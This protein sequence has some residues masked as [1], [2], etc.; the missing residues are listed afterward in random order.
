[1]IARH[2]L[3]ILEILVSVVLLAIV[4]GVCVPFLR[5]PDHANAASEYSEFVS[6][7]DETIARHKQSSADELS[8]EE[9][10]EACIPLGYTC[11]VVH[12]GKSDLGGQWVTVSSDKFMVIRWVRV[13]EEEQP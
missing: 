1:M 12:Q 8:M 3:T 11:S 10:A 2:G 6:H 5:A 4:V 9:L 13:D 7:L